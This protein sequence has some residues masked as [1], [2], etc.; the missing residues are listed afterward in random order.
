MS[1]YRM[2]KE[3]E[4]I[5]DGDECCLSSVEDLWFTAKYSIGLRCAHVG[6]YRRPLLAPPMGAHAD[7]CIGGDKGPCNCGAG[8]SDCQ[9]ALDELVTGCLGETLRS[10]ARAELA[11]LREELKVSNQLL[12]TRDEL[13]NAIPECPNHGA[14]CVP[15]AIEWV[16]SMIAAD[17][18]RTVGTALAMLASDEHDRRLLRLEEKVRE[19]RALLTAQPTSHIAIQNMTKEEFL[20]WQASE[21]TAQPKPTCAT[22]KCC[23]SVGDWNWR[24]ANGQCPVRGTIPN[25]WISPDSFGCIY[26]EPRPEASAK[27]VEVTGGKRRVVGETECPICHV[28]TLHYSV[29]GNGHIHGQCATVDCVNWLE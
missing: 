14:Q 13:L 29:A 17:G 8:E 21:R 3:G 6:T 16:K 26:H 5:L 7:S 18:Q 27:V 4:I 20:A 19:L 2:L 11:A 23:I 22:C 9:S 1:D 10:R 12:E 15:H 25:G 24:C 28:G